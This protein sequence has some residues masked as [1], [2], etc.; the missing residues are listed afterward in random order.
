MALEHFAIRL[1]RIY[2][3]GSLPGVRVWPWQPSYDRAEP[4]ASADGVAQAIDLRP[5]EGKGIFGTGMTDEEGRL[6][7][8]TLRELLSRPGPKR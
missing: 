4:R 5:R 6:R 2:R 3:V 1:A 7:L 8:L